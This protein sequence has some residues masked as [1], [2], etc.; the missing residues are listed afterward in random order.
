MEFE[1]AV[2]GVPAFIII[3]GVYVFFAFTMMTIANK[4]G[5]E[6]AWMAWVPLLNLYLLVRMA[7]KPGWWFILFLVP[8]VNFIVGIYVWML[9]SE[10]RGRPQWWG[11]VIGL[12]PIVNLVLIIM[13]AYTEAE[14]PVTA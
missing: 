14:G 8:L 7:D 13:L 1:F 9:I 5:T 10:R 4:L 6:N 12:V 3:V 11:I 2:T